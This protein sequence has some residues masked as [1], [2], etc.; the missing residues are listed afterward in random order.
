MVNLH[1]NNEKLL[2]KP[3][4]SERVRVRGKAK[5]GVLVL[6]WLKSQEGKGG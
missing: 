2:Q 6:K 5:F 1:D 4:T 3:K